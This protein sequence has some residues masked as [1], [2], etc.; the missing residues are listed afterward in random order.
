MLY[1]WAVG[2]LRN[3]A[4][5]SLADDYLRR[6]ARAGLSIRVDELPQGKGGS[7]R[8]IDALVGRM[9]AIRQSIALDETG[10]PIRSEPFAEQLRRDMNRGGDTAFLIG[11]AAG[12]PRE[13]LAAADLRLSLSA[14]TLPHELA[15]VVLLE[16][17]YRAATILKGMPYHRG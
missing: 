16:Q 13:L 3:E 11:G 2:G 12:L 5:R 6:A 17:L 15:R 8:N 10:D 14:L 7:V 4:M 1:V 9:Q